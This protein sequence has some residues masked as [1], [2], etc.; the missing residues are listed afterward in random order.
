MNMARLMR[1]IAVASAANL[2]MACPLAA[3]TEPGSVPH[4]LRFKTLHVRDQL[5]Q[6]EA[7][8]VLI[9]A[10]WQARGGVV[11]RNVAGHPATAVLTL[12]SPDGCLQLESLPEMPF[13]DGVRENQ[14]AAARMAGPAAVNTMARVNAEG[15]LYYGNEIRRQVQSPAVFVREFVLP[16]C[17]KG[18]DLKITQ[19]VALPNVAATLMRLDPAEPGA[20]KTYHAGKTRIEYALNGQIFEE[21]IH[22]ALQFTEVPAVRTTY[23]SA[24][25]LLAFRAPKGGLDGP[26]CGRIFDTITH[27]FRLDLNWFNKYTQVTRAMI[28]RNIQQIEIIGEASRRWAQTSSQVTDDMMKTWENRSARQDAMRLRFDQHIRDVDEYR[29][30]SG[31]HFELPAGYNAAWVNRSGEYIVTDNRLFNPNVDLQQAGDWTQAQK[32]H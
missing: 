27:S 2:L 24:E 13:V 18:V 26:A 4:Q 23:W 20:R 14:M 30:D 10:G 1:S 7:F 15:R 25:H 21:D 19:E 12:A 6:Q 8:T 28:K 11:W 9:P 5:M 22:C 32:L 3:Q 17:R 31:N 29:D 16:R